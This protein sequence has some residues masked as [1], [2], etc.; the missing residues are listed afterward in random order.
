M[1]DITMC[2]GKDCPIK[3]SCY[4][5]TATPSKFMQ[6]FFLAPP[7]E[8]GKCDYHWKNDK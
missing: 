6:S 2:S 7:Y 3:D 5:H 4:R 8:D 1:P